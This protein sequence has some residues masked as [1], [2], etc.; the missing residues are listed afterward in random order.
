[1]TLTHFRRSAP[2]ESSRSTSDATVSSTDGI[3]AVSRTPPGSR[4]SVCCDCWKARTLCGARFVTIRF[5][6][7]VKVV[8]QC[9]PRIDVLYN[10]HSVLEQ[11]LSFRNRA[12]QPSWE[13]SC[14]MVTLVYLMAVGHDALSPDVA[15]VCGDTHI[16]MRGY[17]GESVLEHI[18][19]TLHQ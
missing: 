17:S 6:T 14:G 8:R 1:M 3:V 11:L 7:G 13:H 16:H 15:A 12:P 10:V 5:V 2:G 18:H 4:S 9:D 19:E